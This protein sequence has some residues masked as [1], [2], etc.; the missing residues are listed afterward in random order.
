MGGIACKGS[1]L[2]GTGLWTVGRDKVSIRL[3]DGPHGVRKPLSDLTLQEAHPATCFP[4]G[5]ALACSWD[6]NLLE[7][8]GMALAKECEHYDIQVFFRHSY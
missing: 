1:N 7:T 2:R 5:C 3:S 6:V 8:V 4:A